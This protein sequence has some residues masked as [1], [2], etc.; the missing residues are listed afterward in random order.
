MVATAMYT[1]YVGGKFAPAVSVIRP[2]SHNRRRRI[3]GLDGSKTFYPPEARAASANLCPFA[4]NARRRSML[5][6]KVAS[7]SCL[8]STD[9]PSSMAADARRTGTA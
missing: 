5:W 2:S 1:V 7:I 3:G 6:S 8:A 9:R 4:T